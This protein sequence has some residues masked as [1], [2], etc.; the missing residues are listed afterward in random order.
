[1]SLNPEEELT[2]TKGREILF[3]TTCKMIEEW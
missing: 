1:M 3:F 2:T